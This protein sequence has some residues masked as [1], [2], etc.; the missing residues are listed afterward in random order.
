LSADAFYEDAAELNHTLSTWFV[1]Q[2]GLK[3]FAYLMARLRRLYGRDGNARTAEREWRNIT[4]EVARSPSALDALDMEIRGAITRLH[5][6]Y[7]VEYQRLEAR[8]NGVIESPLTSWDL[9][10]LNLD[11]DDDANDWD[12]HAAHTTDLIMLIADYN[13]FLE[14]WD[15]LCGQLSTSQLRALYEVGKIIASRTG[16]GPDGDGKHIH[17]PGSWQPEARWFLEHRRS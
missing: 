9:D 11:F 1:S 2:F 8:V 16:L 10:V 17:F 6:A 13:S 7:A 4:I 14:L 15:R 3:Q 12:S 5:E